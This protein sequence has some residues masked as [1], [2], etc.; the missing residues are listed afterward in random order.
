M[1]PKSA[2]DRFLKSL[3]FWTQPEAQRHDRVLDASTDVDHVVEKLFDQLL[4]RNSI[5]PT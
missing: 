3:N 2:E 4:G 5:P 1:D